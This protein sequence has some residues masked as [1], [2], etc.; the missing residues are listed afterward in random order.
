MRRVAAI[1]FV[2]V[3][4]ASAPPVGATPGA[5]ADGAQVALADWV[6]MDSRTH[7]TFYFAIGVRGASPGGVYSYGAFGSGD[8]TV[9]RSKHWTTVL[10]EGSGR[11]RD[12]GLDQ[13][14]FDPAMRSA[15]LS[16]KERGVTNTAVWRGRGR[17]PSTGASLYSGGSMVGADAMTG[18]MASAKA[19]VFGQRMPKHSPMNFAVLVQGVTAIAYDDGDAKRAFEFH[20]DGRYTYSVE[21]RLPR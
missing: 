15:A 11:A 18:R 13:F 6:V 12:V 2:V 4:G 5:Y 9:R 14:D 17:A 21:V 1:L 7:G 20:A 3:L 16:V 19:R 10:C 8:C